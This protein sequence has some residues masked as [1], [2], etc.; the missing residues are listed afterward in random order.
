MANTSNK[1][2]ANTA[3]GGTLEAAFCGKKPATATSSAART[4]SSV[5]PAE[6]DL[7]EHR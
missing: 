4:G 2:S 1:G 3:L 7:P 6:S 5:L